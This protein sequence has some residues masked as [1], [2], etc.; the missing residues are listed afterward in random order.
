MY[1]DNYPKITTEA[2]MMV[3]IQLIK[4]NAWGNCVQCLSHS[5]RSAD[6]SVISGCITDKS[7]T[8]IIAFPWLLGMCSSLCHWSINSIDYYITLVG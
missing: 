2:I 6:R 4:C 7:M 1:I 8:E 3:W 5:N